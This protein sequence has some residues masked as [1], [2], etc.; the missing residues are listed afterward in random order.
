[1]SFFFFGLEASNMAVLAV[2]PFPFCVCHT[3]GDP[4]E[5]RPKESGIGKPQQ[6]N[7]GKYASV[8]EKA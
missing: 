1:M 5:D 2:V 4:K 8:T 3:R 7:N 6:I